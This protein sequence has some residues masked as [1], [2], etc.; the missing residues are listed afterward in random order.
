MYFKSDFLFFFNCLSEVWL[1]LSARTDQRN[2]LSQGPFHQ[3]RSKACTLGRNQLG[4]SCSSGYPIFSP[5]LG[6]P[7]QS[8]LSAPVSASIFGHVLPHSPGTVPG[9]IAPRSAPET[10]GGLAQQRPQ[11]DLPSLQQT[12]QDQAPAVELPGKKK[13]P[14]KSDIECCC[15]N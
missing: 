11:S 4:P 7:S 2:V 13:N 8:Y 9:Q 3:R 10:N 15:I 6:S 1:H 14:P 12:V 5:V